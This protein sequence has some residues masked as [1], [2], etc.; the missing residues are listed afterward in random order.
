VIE[1]Y[2]HSLE[3][4][5]GYAKAE[6]KLQGKNID[7]VFPELGHGNIDSFIKA[8]LF[9]TTYARELWT[10]LE[11][12]HPLIGRLSAAKTPFAKAA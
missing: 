12:Q 2:L 10:T 8:P 7:E 6:Y 4:S 9:A 1:G 11:K 3:A 5:Y